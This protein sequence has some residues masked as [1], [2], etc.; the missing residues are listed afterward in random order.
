MKYFVI[1]DFKTMFRTQTT[2]KIYIYICI[3]IHI[4]IRCVYTKFHIPGYKQLN[5]ITQYL[6]FLSQLT[7]MHNSIAFSVTLR[8]GQPVGMYRDFRSFL[9]SINSGRR[10]MYWHEICVVV[11]C[12]TFFWNFCFF[13]CSNAV[14]YYYKHAEGFHAKCSDIFVLL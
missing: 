7:G 10:M 13:P 14:K 9:N 2:Y 11:L 4:Y 3:Y 8:H 1:Y 12:K 6:Y 5:I